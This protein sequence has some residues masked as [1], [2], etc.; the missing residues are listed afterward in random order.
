MLRQSVAHNLSDAISGFE[1]ELRNKPT[2]DGGNCDFRG[3][4]KAAEGVI[5][6]MRIEKALADIM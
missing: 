1:R 4:R 5:S 2:S 6:L 3:G